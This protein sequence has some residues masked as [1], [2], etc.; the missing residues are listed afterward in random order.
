MKDLITTFISK[1]KTLIKYR[2]LKMF[3]R[4]KML[5]YYP[6]LVI[7]EKNIQFYITL[8][9]KNSVGSWSISADT[10]NSGIGLKAKTTLKKFWTAFNQYLE[11]HTIFWIIVNRYLTLCARCVVFFLYRSHASLPVVMK[12]CPCSF[13]SAVCRRTVPCRQCKSASFGYC[14]HFTL[15]FTFGFV[16]SRCKKCFP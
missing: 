1:I 9:R 10:Q 5:K 4:V 15:L 8:I 7:K 13:R 14:K 16:T 2:Y 3:L 12:G 6:P 11:K